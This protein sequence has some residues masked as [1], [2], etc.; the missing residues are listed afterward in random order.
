MMKR[1]VVTGMGLV[2]PS[3]IGVIPSFQNLLSG[4]GFVRKVPDDLYYFGVPQAFHPVEGA[5]HPIGG[6]VNLDEESMKKQCGE[7]YEKMGRK[8]IFVYIATHE[9]LED[10]KWNPNTLR[11]KNRTGLVVASAFNNLHEMGRNAALLHVAESGS[12]EDLPQYFLAQMTVPA[13]HQVLERNFTG[14]TFGVGAA[15]AGGTYAIATAA[16]LIQ[17]GSAD[18]IVCGGADCPL[19]VLGIGAFQRL[20]AHTPEDSPLSPEDRV[21]PFDKKRCGTA[22]AEGAAVLILEDYNHALVHF[23]VFLS[24]F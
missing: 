13:L 11:E 8:D 15:C 21:R 22:L 2:A 7:M 4:Q 3:G 23:S 24:F 18:V 20:K 17:N 12:V 14:P 16:N 1:V 9:A 19:S 10:A 6:I 5:R